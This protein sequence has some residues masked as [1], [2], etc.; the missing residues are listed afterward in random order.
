[1]YVFTFIV[2]AVMLPRQVKTFSGI[3][4]GLPFSVVVEIPLR[5]RTR[6]QRHMSEKE[7]SIRSNSMSNS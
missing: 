5:G 4:G 1:M 2:V 3:N 7:E 6:W